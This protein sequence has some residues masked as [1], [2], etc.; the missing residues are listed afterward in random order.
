MSL[1]AM[2]SDES[3]T[4]D[5]ANVAAPELT[6]IDVAGAVDDLTIDDP[7]VG[8]DTITL[9]LNFKAF[10]DHTP[11]TEHARRVASHNDPSVQDFADQ[12]LELA[13]L[14]AEVK[15]LTRDFEGLQIAVSVRDRRIE[16]LHEQLAFARREAQ[17][18][19]AAVEATITA[20]LD[21]ALA[22]APARSV[23]KP[24]V[25][26]TDV[27]PSLSTD[28]PVPVVT[29]VQPRPTAAPEPAVE[30]PTFAAPNVPASPPADKPAPAATSVQPRTAAAPEPA[31]AKPA[32]TA[33]D[34]LAV[35]PVHKP[36]PGTTA[37]QPRTAAASEPPVP[38]PDFSSTVV[39]TPPP[40][41][42]SAPAAAHPAAVPAQR[43]LISLDR[44]NEAIALSR[45]VVTIGRTRDSDIC[46]PSGAV[47]R[48]HARLLLSPRSV[49][50]VDMGSANGSFV[51]DEPIKRHRLRDGDVLRIGDRSYRFAS[52][53]HPAQ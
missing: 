16:R 1:Q 10:A 34:V 14:R 41:D 32:F 5:T 44:S 15:R 22:A 48:D 27:L 3:A 39:L 52:G 35:P 42:E 26:T 17:S 37:V 8:V 29:S 53:P 25:T 40:A 21:Q 31:V 18:S 28:K 49:T 43:Q 30:K 4:G 13:T 20:R 51:N 7:A 50:I 45:D 36:A 12:A 46:I 38:T 47:S 23:A 11:P 2:P 9:E 24:N 33:T 6:A 19:A